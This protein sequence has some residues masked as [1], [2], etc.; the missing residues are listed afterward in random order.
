MSNASH[1]VQWQEAMNDLLEQVHLE[2]ETLEMDKAGMDEWL[3]Q[4][5]RTLEAAAAGTADSPNLVA[6]E[7]YAI[8]YIKYMQIFK[9]L[10][11]AYDNLVHPQKR[12]DLRLVLDAVMTRTVELKHLL[13]YWNNTGGQAYRFG[14]VAQ[15]KPFAWE[16]VH[17]DD[18]LVDLK[19]PPETLEV[20]IPS[21]FVE[22]AARD[23]TARRDRLIEGLAGLENADRT[24]PLPL[25][26]PGKN[27]L[28]IELS[29]DEAI[30]CIQRNERGRQGRGRA[31]LVKEL[32]EE[33]IQRQQYDSR[34]Q[35][36]IDPEL[37]A[38]HL[39]RVFRG[40]QSRRA[41]LRERDAELVFIGMRPKETK[42]TASIESMLKE[43]YIK[44]K[45]EQM[46]NQLELDEELIKQH[47]VVRDEEGPLMKEKMLDE[48]REWFTQMLVRGIFPSAE[49]AADVQ[50]QFSAW[51]KAMAGGIQAEDGD[52]DGG[53]GKGGKK[54]KKG[55]KDDKKGGK[56]KK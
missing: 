29:L 24:E 37:A 54:G 11:A 9:R 28:V 21:Y 55:G 30:E 20:P 51:Q 3:G 16:Y 22:G 6:F 31:L 56:E 12:M 50:E 36:D 13:V 52:G 18:I 40:Y 2:D 23:K 32:R 5:Q 49:N 38:T 19:L 25:E 15:N 41:A 44:R 47:K 48:R 35:E 27:D 43:S 53:D 8:L 7:F 1:N 42:E 10:D 46:E 4:Q 26:E 39:Q 17:L 34:T 14:D 33:E 45:D